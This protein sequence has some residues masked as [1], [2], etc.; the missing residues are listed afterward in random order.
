MVAA[1]LQSA[2]PE[3]SALPAAE[4][5]PFLWWDAFWRPRVELSVERDEARM[6]IRA[7]DAV[8][9]VTFERNELRGKA[10]FFTGLLAE[11]AGNG[12]WAWTGRLAAA[13]P[14]QDAF[15]Q[16]QDSGPLENLYLAIRAARRAVRDHPN[17]A[18]AFLLLGEAYSR[19]LRQSRERVWCVEFPRLAEIRAVQLLSAFQ[20]AADLEPDSLQIHKHLAQFY[21]SLDFNDLALEHLKRALALGRKSGLPSAEILRLEAGI[22]RLKKDVDDALDRYDHIAHNLRVEERASLGKRHGL[23]GK[24]LDVLLA[25]ELA[26][27]GKK[28][29]R[30]ELDLLLNTGR[31][32]KVLAWL[33]PQLEPDLGPP[34]YHWIKAQAEAAV[35]QYPESD[36]DLASV[37]TAG[38][39]PIPGGVLKRPVELALLA[40]A[41]TLLA[42]TAGG[43]LRALAFPTLSGFPLLEQLPPRLEFALHFMHTEAS[44]TVLRGILAL[45]SGAVSE[46]RTHFRAASAFWS[47]PAG[48]GYVD[49]GS[50]MCRRICAFF[51]EQAAP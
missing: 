49:A 39:P 29:L 4:A 27:F 17:D 9:E 41:N 31:P 32:D 25:S 26:A 16:S 28:G 21:T 11:A 43:P 47:S 12:A 34:I 22:A 46:A 20:H 10:L 45:E 2:G 30:M 6:L 18:E 40:L 1:D 15:V 37:V 36:R 44:M 51:L 24:A 33:T 13:A 14:W 48:R 42:E 38:L 35:G 50:R 8:Q 23:A 3:T 7:F 19:L 5:R